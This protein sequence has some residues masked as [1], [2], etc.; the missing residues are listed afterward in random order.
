MRFEIENRA[1]ANLRYSAA[2]GSGS[3]P[4]VH[5]RLDGTDFDG[6]VHDVLG[7]DFGVR[8]VQAEGATS[9]QS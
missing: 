5:E 2:L 3:N 1:C 4:E 7:L 8:W 6:G 9:C